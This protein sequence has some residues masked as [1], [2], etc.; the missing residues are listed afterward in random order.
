MN[1]RM[2]L[3]L[4]LSAGFAVRSVVLQREFVAAVRTS[5]SDPPLVV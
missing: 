5:L 1:V 2:T 3:I 4:L